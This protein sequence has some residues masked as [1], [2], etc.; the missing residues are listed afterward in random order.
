MEIVPKIIIAGQR[1]PADER[2]GDL[3]STLKN[4]FSEMGIDVLVPSFTFSEQEVLT[5]ANDVIAPEDF[6]LNFRLGERQSIVYT[7]TSAEEMALLFQKELILRTKEQYSDPI[8]SKNPKAFLKKIPCHSWGITLPETLSRKELLFTMMGCVTDLYN[9]PHSLLSIDKQWPFR[10]VP[11]SHFAF[12]A[13][14]KAKQK[15]IIPGYRGD[16]LLPNGGLTRGE[17][18]YVLDKLGML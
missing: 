13:I 6:F 4:K 10:D 7:D 3:L 2:I 9:T 18:F 1:H 5:W 16:I 11:S 8:F 15:G 14:K 12:P 17:F